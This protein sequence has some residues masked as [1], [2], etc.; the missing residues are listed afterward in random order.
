MPGNKYFYGST[1]QPR[2][3]A[4]PDL[5]VEERDEEVGILYMPDGSQHV[6]KQEANRVPFG[7]C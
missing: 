7:F 4:Q 5:D 2:V 1:A 6:V 3:I